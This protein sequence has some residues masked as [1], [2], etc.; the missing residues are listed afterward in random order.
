MTTRLRRFVGAALTAMIA[1]VVLAA[2]GSVEPRSYETG[3]RDLVLQLIDIPGMLAD[4]GQPASIMPTF[5]MYGDGRVIVSVAGRQQGALPEVRELRLSKERV[6]Q[7]VVAAL[8]AGVQGDNDVD[9]DVGPDAP[10]SIITLT[11]EGRT[12]ASRLGPEAGGALGELRDAMRAY[13]RE[14][15]ATP[16]TPRD[17]IAVL[18]VARASDEKATPWPFEQIRPGADQE[19][20]EGT[21][22]TIYRR[23]GVGD[24]AAAARSASPDTLWS[25]GNETFSVRFRPVLP[26]ESDCA[27]LVPKHHTSDGTEG[28]DGDNGG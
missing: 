19:I 25:S 20:V 13:A 2:C 15:T 28:S 3:P 8:D 26:H 6:E 22:C 18:A 9:I 5:S 12:G 24:V 10:T 4:P 17:G 11:A 16:F 14:K 27:S 1:P 23:T 21:Y 7:I